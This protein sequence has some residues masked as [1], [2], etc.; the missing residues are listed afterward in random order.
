[1]SYVIGFIFLFAY[2]LGGWKFWSGFRQTNFEQNL[3]KRLYLSALWLPLLVISKSYR[4]NY[5]RALKGK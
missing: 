3:I 2:I 1:M 5:Q 4:K